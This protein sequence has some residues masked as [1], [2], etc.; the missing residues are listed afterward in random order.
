MREDDKGA[1][2]TDKVVVYAMTRNIYRQIF[3]SVNSLLEHTKVDRIY[4]LAEDD[5]LPFDLPGPVTVINV[6]KQPYFGKC[7]PN[8]DNHWSYM[9]LMKAALYDLLRA[10]KRVLMLDLD[11]VIMEDI[12]ELWDYDLTGYYFA[13]VPEFQTTKDKGYLYCNFGVVML[14]LE[15]LRDGTGDRIV[16]AL[17]TQ[18]YGFPEQDAYNEYCHDH[19]LTLGGEWNSCA[20][21]P[22]TLAVKIKHYAGIGNWTQWRDA[23]KYAHKEV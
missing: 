15:K 19:V 17:N 9:V 13:A 11:T 4:I 7:G 5:K 12:S 10:E 21:C 16:T 6:S 14:N 3:V 18:K 22:F 1:G 20:F 2:R 8:Y 23:K